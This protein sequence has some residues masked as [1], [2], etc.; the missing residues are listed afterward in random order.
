MSKNSQPDFYTRIYEA[1]HRLLYAIAYKYLKT[2]GDCLDVIQEVFLEL[3]KKPHL[4]EGMCDEDAKKYLC[5]SVR[6]RCFNLLYKQR[7]ILSMDAE[8][9][10]LSAHIPEMPE[11]VDRGELADLVGRVVESLPERYKSYL[12]MKYV[13]EYSNAQI[14]QVL[15]VKL[16]SLGVIQQRAKSLYR[17]EWLNLE[18]NS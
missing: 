9:L 11:F 18:Q 3:I 14:A 7:G 10:D 16:E 15:G 5:M 4:M 12:I 1:N 6:N 17:K 13:Y 2:Q 8:E